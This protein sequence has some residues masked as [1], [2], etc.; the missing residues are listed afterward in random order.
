MADKHQQP[1]SAHSNMAN[2]LG[3]PRKGE[4]NPSWESREDFPETPTRGS[5][6]SQDRRGQEGAPGISLNVVMI[7]HDVFRELPGSLCY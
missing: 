6:V 5:R 2:T 1:A 3:G 7:L 4:F